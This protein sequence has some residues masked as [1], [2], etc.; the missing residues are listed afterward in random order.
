MR[1]AIWA[2]STVLVLCAASTISV[3][4]QQ[5]NA[6]QANAKPA[7]TVDAQQKAVTDLQRTSQKLRDALAV[8]EKEAPG[9]NRDRAAKAARDAVQNVQDAMT[10]LQAQAKVAQARATPPA[11][12]GSTGGRVSSAEAMKRLRSASDTLYDAVHALAK[13][14]A[15]PER[16]EAIKKADQALFE[17][18]QAAMLSELDYKL[19]VGKAK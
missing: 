13:L 18:E 6:A 5:T 3:Q 7:A 1:K 17:T 16:N 15:G 4:A 12:S 19:P 14:P 2:A 8:L 11:A 10:H 9:P